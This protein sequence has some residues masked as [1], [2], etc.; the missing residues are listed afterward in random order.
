[1]KEDSKRFLIRLLLLTF[2]LAAGIA[3]TGF[4]MKAYYFR[5]M[6]V[7]LLF[8]SGLT[9]FTFKWLVRAATGNFARFTRIN[10]LAT[11]LRL[12]IYIIVFV[13]CLLLSNTRPVVSLIFIGILYFSFSVF[14]IYH[15]SKYLRVKQ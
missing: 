2:L 12:V 4:F 5:M 10:M 3:L 13:M 8:F 11:F 9:W 7:V 6:P 14:E 1:M 15:L